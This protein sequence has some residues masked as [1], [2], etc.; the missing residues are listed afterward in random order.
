MRIRN[1]AVSGIY[2]FSLNFLLFQSLTVSAKSTAQFSVAAELGKAV[3]EKRLHF[4]LMTQR[5]YRKH[6]YQSFWFNSDALHHHLWS[7]TELISNSAHYGLDQA[8]YHCDR[9][10]AGNINSL[11]HNE[12]TVVNKPWLDVLLTDAMITFICDLHYGKA[13]PAFPKTVLDD[14]TFNGLKA[15]SVL[16]AALSGATFREAVLGVQPLFKG[17]RE[18]LDYNIYLVGQLSGDCYEI[19]PDTIKLIALNLERWRW[20]NSVSDDYIIIN[21]AAFTLNYNRPDGSTEFRIITG[22]PLTPTPV[23]QSQ[24]SFFTTMPEWNVPR[25]IIKKRIL[26]AALKDPSYLENNDFKIYTRSGRL[27]EPTVQNLRQ[28]RSDLSGYVIRQ[29][30]GCDHPLGSIMFNLDRSG[31]IY[32]HEAADKGL[33]KHE[34]RALSKGCIQV[35]DPERLANLFVSDNILLNQKEIHQ[36]IKEGKHRKF[37]LSNPVPVIISYFTCEAKNGV[38]KTFRDVYNRDRSLAEALKF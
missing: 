16:Q 30:P 36:A 23:L 2:W 12:E 26:P 6:A 20:L 1:V 9:V 33:F 14:E 18:L 37:I 22:E 3:A 10:T 38:F 21:L 29:Y 11:L 27:I 5:I 28:V 34:I 19:P 25:R 15:D 7:A 13:N 31:G 8:D 24:I 35:E 4:P 17:Y 32:I